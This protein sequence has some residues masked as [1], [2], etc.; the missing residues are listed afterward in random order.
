[1]PAI[2]ATSD[3][4]AAAGL[5]CSLL[6]QLTY[7]IKYFILRNYFTLSTPARHLAAKFQFNT[8]RPSSGNIHNFKTGADLSAIITQLGLKTP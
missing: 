8:S 5:S 6:S 4:L 3:G 7:V 2:G 1:M